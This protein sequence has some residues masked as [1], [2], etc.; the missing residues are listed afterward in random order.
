MISRICAS[1]ILL[2]AS[3]ALSACADTAD[4]QAESLARWKA[5]CAS[6]HKQFLWH[7]TVADRGVIMETVTLNGRCVGPGEKGYQ[8]P[9]PPDDEP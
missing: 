2:G 5:L 6:Q 4:I 7:D 1:A 3:I 8:P 9:A